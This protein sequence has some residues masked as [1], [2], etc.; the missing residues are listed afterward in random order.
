M[1]NR[2][3]SSPLIYPD[4]DKFS[5]SGFSSDGEFQLTEPCKLSQLKLSITTIKYLRCSAKILDK[6]VEK[7]P[8]MQYISSLEAAETLNSTNTFKE[9]LHTSVTILQI[10]MGFQD[11][12]QRS[13]QNPAEKNLIKI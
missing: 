12:V 10:C 1:Y 13:L 7:Y 3:F 5:V 11:S 6:V 9:K 2:T 8:K 4:W